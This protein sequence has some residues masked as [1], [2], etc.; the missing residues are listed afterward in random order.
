MRLF[1]L[2]DPTCIHTKRWIS[3]LSSY[4][5]DIFLFGLSGRD[6]SYYNQFDNVST[7]AV[8]MVNERVKNGT[9]KKIVY[10]KVLKILKHKIKE[11]KPDILHA[12]YA[13]SYGLLGALLDIHPYVISVWGS[14]VYDFPRVSF[15]HKLLLK[16]NF[17]KADYLLS[18]SHVMAKETQRYTDKSIK[19]TPFGVDVN[20]FKKNDIS[21]NKEKEI[22]IGNVKA[23]TPKYG[24]DILIKAFK[25]VVDDNLDKQIKLKIIG[26]GADKDNL[27]QLVLDLEIA[28]KVFF[29]GKID[30]N[31]LP[32][33]YN[34]FDIFV[35]TSV[36]D[37]ESFGVVAVE[38]MACECPVIVSDADGFTE[39][40]A[41]QETGIIVPK[42]DIEATAKAIQNLIDNKDLRETMGKQGRKR[43]EELYNWEKN[44]ELMISIYREILSNRN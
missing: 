12:H 20:L 8:D 21:D 4:E 29:L 10:L 37:S 14:D 1:I 24:I 18:T 19:I 30:N 5:I 22:I 38:A 43:V 9:L 34:H 44:V 36:L 27:Q 13:S 28:D 25:K 2:S 31:L 11:F 15:L 3:A 40:V 7:F 26:E 33:Y 17:S 35:S 42:K 39:V 6:L 32:E 16:Y 23:L 41:N